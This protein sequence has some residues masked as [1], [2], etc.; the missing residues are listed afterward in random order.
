M[1]ELLHRLLDVK[2]PW[3]WGL[4][5]AKAFRAVKSLLRYD[6]V[7]IQ[8]DE[9]LPLVLVCNTLPYG[10]GA[11]LS[12][13]LTNGSE[14]PLAF[15]SRTFSLPERNYSQLDKE[16]LDI[17]AGIKCFH[18]Y[19]YGRH[20]DL[21]MD[22]KPLLG[23]LASDRQMPQDL[24]PR[25]S[26]WTVFLAAYNYSLYHRPGFVLFHLHSSPTDFST[27]QYRIRSRTES[28]S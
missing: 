25:M 3:A 13:R 21:I 1:A 28:V 14:A 23:F 7:L 9:H 22:H 2:K 26:C 6:S 27:Q 5:E 15:F 18:E 11:V 12:H 16:A 4:R 20:F 10:V 17:V 24:S 19:L 8:Y